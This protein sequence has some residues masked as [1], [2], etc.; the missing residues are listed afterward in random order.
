MVGYE[1]KSSSPLRCNYGRGNYE[2][3]EWKRSASC[4]TRKNVARLTRVIMRNTGI[5]NVR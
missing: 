5:S 4:A 1:K 2:C 3:P